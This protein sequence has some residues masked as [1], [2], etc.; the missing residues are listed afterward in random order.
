MT[1]YMYEVYYSEQGRN[2]IPEMS[3]LYTSGICAK[4]TEAI[5]QSQAWAR[6]INDPIVVLYERKEIA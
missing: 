6:T 3:D 2:G 1:D 5:E 4:L